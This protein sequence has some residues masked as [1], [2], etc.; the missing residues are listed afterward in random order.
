MPPE[1][2]RIDF[3]PRKGYFATAETP[4]ADVTAS[5]AAALALTSLVIAGQDAA[6]AEKSLKY[7]RGTVQVRREIPG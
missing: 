1:L 4:A 6:Y 7:A 3:C 2:R 5:A